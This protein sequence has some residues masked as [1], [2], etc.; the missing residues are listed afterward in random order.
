MYEDE[1]H[2]LDVVKYLA[3]RGATAKMPR[4]REDLFTSLEAF[5]TFCGTHKVPPTVGGFAVWNGVSVQ[6][7]NQI[8]RDRSD[9]RSEAI[10][11]CKDSI[12]NFLELCA[13]DSSL[14]P[15]VYFHQN[16]VYYGAVE[17]QTVTL[18]LERND[19]ELTPE[20]QRERVA[21]LLGDVIDVE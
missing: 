15:I 17:N 4:T 5:F 2:K 1:G 7:V 16:K 21:L 9:A 10:S 11:V 14:N 13:M 12:R 8:E 3:R 6:R 18:Q 19:A 20:E